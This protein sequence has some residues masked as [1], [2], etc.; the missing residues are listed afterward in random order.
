MNGAA[1]YVGEMWGAGGVNFKLQAAETIKAQAP[2]RGYH[3]IRA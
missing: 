2:T 3:R 1:P